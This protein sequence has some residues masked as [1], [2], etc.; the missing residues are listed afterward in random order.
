MEGLFPS[1]LETLCLFSDWDAL[2]SDQSEDALLSCAIDGAGAL[3]KSRSWLSTNV[4]L[5]HVGHR[6]LG[7][8]QVQKLEEAR[9][10]CGE[11]GVSLTVGCRESS[12]YLDTI[13]P[14]SHVF[15]GVW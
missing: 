14:S 3:M 2:C 7:D 6:N 1:S 13:W 11:N 9:R 10:R 15:S 4:C 5:R 8:P 12:E